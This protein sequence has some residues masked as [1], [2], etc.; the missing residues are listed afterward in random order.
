MQQ[1][2]LPQFTLQPRLPIYVSFFYVNIHLYSPFVVLYCIML[3]Y[4]MLGNM[5]CNVYFGDDI[6]IS[7]NTGIVGKIWQRKAKANVKQCKER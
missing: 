3:F 1:G 2:V 5:L 7:G 6:A 4:V